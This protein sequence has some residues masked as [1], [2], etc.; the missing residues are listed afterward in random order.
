MFLKTLRRGAPADWVLRFHSALQ[1][2]AEAKSVETL[3]EVAFKE[4]LALAQAEVGSLF[5]VDEEKQELV[6]RGASSEYLSQFPQVRRSLKEGIL[7][8]VAGRRS[9]LLVEDTH[10]HPEFRNGNGFSGYRTTSFI[11]IPLILH[12]KLVGILNLTDKKSRRPFSKKDLE[13]MALFADCLSLYI[14]K[15]HLS[16]EVGGS[17]GTIHG[18]QQDKRRLEAEL[19]LSQKMASIG[20]LAAGIAHELNN[21]LDG[22]L[23]Y[24]HL[25]L[26][27][28]KEDDTVREYLLEVKQG[29][30]RMANIVKNLLAFSRRQRVALK[31]VD[32]NEV[33]ENVLSNL[34][35]SAYPSRVEIVKAYHPALPLLLDKGIDQI[36]TNVI[37][38]ALEAMPHGGILRIATL[39]N[40]K[41]LV[42]RISDT[43]CGIA[44]EDRPYIFEPFFTTKEIDKGCGLG[45]A[46][47][48]EIIQAYEGRIVV[49]SEKNRGA[50]FFIHLP[51]KYAV[52]KERSLS[53][54]R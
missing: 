11:S 3:W 20:K 36:F 51:L 52:L 41:E 21:P 24:I 10:R 40:D 6:L 28:L 15:N 54:A 37:K 25:S 31:P 44:K 12:G 45:L 8:Y 34:L 35:D 27:H 13:G 2:M 47:C 30:D 42:V 29:L 16:S 48:Y 9:P 38:N 46:I 39:K 5:V 17:R 19:E 18:L 53:Y 22:T 33:L 4:A 7:G 50:T 32:V 14:E 49:E 26:N 1:K 43:G 23:R